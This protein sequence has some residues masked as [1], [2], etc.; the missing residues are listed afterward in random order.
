MSRLIDLPIAELII[1]ERS[2]SGYRNVKSLARS[3]SERGL[4]SPINVRSAD[5]AMT[6]VC[7]GRRVEAAKSL[8][9][10]TIPALLAESEMDELHALLAEGDENTER[11][12][13]TPAE[14]I[15]HRQRIH[16]AEAGAAKERQDAGREK[17]HASR[18]G[19]TGPLGSS[20]LEQ[21]KTP[22]PETK[23]RNRTAKA[24]GYSATT[25]DKAQEV[26]D[27][28]EDQTQPGPVQLAA[29]QAAKNL[30]APGAKVDREFRA[31]K[32]AVTKSN[33]DA[34]A[35]EFRKNLLKAL[36]RE[37][38]IV[39]F[40]PQRVADITEQDDLYVIEQQINSYIDWWNK[41]KAARGSGLRAI[42]GGKS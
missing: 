32:E 7:G 41:I 23:T 17:S 31:Y 26:T 25:L 22:S 30:E 24:T 1:S 27:A 18:R 37:Q 13:F 6:L 35:A 11:E 20:K 12:P 15:R 9:W 4:L 8:N 21:P 36:G 34:A 38:S 29:K 40:D 2:R 10:T 39:S 16:E 5:G 19:E 42:N 28:A 14:A 3:I 33:P